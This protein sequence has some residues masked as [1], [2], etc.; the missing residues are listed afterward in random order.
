MSPSLKKGVGMA[1]VEAAFARPETEFWIDIRGK[2]HLA[3]TVERPFYRKPAAR[4]AP[5][6]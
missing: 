2:M 1:L 5:H 3:K 6:V 4:P